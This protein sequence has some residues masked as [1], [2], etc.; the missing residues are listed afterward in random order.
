MTLVTGGE[1]PRHSKWHLMTGTVMLLSAFVVTMFTLERYMHDRPAS[2]SNAQVCTP[3]NPP[4]QPTPLRV[5]S[6]E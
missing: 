5:A 1:S 4:S 2:S 6:R 3:A